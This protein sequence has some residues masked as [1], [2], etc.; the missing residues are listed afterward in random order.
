MRTHKSKQNKRN[1]RFAAKGFHVSIRN[2]YPSFYLCSLVV[3]GI[4]AGISWSFLALEHPG[5][6]AFDPQYNKELEPK[7]FPFLRTFLHIPKKIFTRS[8]PI[9]SNVVIQ[10]KKNPNKPNGE[11]IPSQALLVVSVNLRFC[12]ASLL[13]K[14]GLWKNPAGFCIPG[15]L[16]L[17]VSWQLFPP[18]KL[19]HLEQ[20]HF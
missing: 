14:K 20:E 6:A 3:V 18:L 15:T 9:L 8:C 5:G 2:C 7:Y 13:L 10:A 11:K 1:P 4:P 12:L 17:C 19:I 16:G